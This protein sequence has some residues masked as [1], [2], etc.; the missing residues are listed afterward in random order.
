MICWKFFIKRR[1]HFVKT[2]NE[3]LVI[4]RLKRAEKH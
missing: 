2:Y 1:N 3:D 4:H